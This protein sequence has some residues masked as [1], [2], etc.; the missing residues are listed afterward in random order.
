MTWSAIEIGVL[1][2]AVSH[3][4][5]VHNSQPWAL[6]VRG[7]TADLYER[8]G[9]ALPRHDPTGRDRVLSCGAALT[10]LELAVRALG[11]QPA[12]TLLPDPARP[13]LVASVVAAG[14]AEATAAEVDRYSAMF[15]R[16]SYRA[17]FAL[18]RVP[19]GMLRALTAATGGP[20]TEG[21]LV[22]PRTEASELADLL[23][24]AGALLRDDRAYQRELAAWSSQFRHPLDEDGTLPWAGIVRADTHLPDRIT[25][26]ERITAESLL[27]VLTADD[28]RLDHLCA[29]AALQQAWLTAVA[30]GLAGSVLTQPLH[31]PEV[32]AGLIER[33][34]LPGYPQAILRF[35]YPVTAVGALAGLPPA[36]GAEYRRT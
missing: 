24:H 31:L 4:P 6:E 36:E 3:A 15:R 26:A 19:R 35:G 12:V 11:R 9:V 21:R 27:I 23:S 34:A 5:S 18:H 25:L 22:E 32:R 16:A 2:R 10:N 14:R 20:G 28:T 1:A 17:P 13:D 7:G 8:P 29:G 33:L 30:A